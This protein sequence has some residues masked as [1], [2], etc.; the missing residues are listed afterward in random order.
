MSAPTTAEW[1]R[2]A[3]RRISCGVP[4]LTGRIIRRST[5]ATA[6]RA[7]GIR[8][9]VRAWLGESSGLLD[10]AMRW[11]MLAAAG[12]LVWTVA[13]IALGA[14]GHAVAGARWLMW[15]GTAILVVATYRA[16]GKAD[17]ADA[18]EDPDT[19]PDES[20]P[21]A[22][23][24]PEDDEQPLDADLLADV[25]HAVARGG[26]VHLTAITRRLRAET[27]Q[28]WDVLAACRAHGI[29]TRPVRVA[30]A[31]PAVTTGIHRADLPPLP[32]PLSA[33]PVGVVS[34]GQH[35]NNNSNNATVE[36][37]GEGGLLVKHGPTDRQE[38]RR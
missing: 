32:Q 16:G 8:T 21:P 3:A 19:A 27:G 4:I 14:G 29:R 34:A 7:A 22:E 12:W 1:L 38:A 18:Q 35:G 11:A 31:D 33:P 15:P 30:G 37:F 20:V 2:D 13:S 24:E 23:L 28:H 26:N 36:E 5:K 9:G 25:I 10:T 6:R 17:A